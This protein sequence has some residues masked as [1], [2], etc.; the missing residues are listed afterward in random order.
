MVVSSKTHN[1]SMVR[2]QMT[3]SYSALKMTFTSLPPR[4]TEH[5]TGIALENE[6]QR[7]WKNAIHLSFQNMT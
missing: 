2:D 7:M 3:T 4:L 6:N 5:K 1:W